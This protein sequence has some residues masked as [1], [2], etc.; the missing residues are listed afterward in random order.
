M[1]K[2]K[3]IMILGAGCYQYPLIKKAKAMELETYVVSCSGA[4]PGIS[5]ADHYLELDT[6]DIEGV[7]RA[8]KDA[9]IDGVVTTGTDVCLPTLGKIVDELQLRGTGFEA[10]CKCADKAA[11]K[12]TFARYDIPNARFTVVQELGQ[13]EKG[14]AGIGYPVMIKATDS[15]GSRGI[16]RVDHP[17]QL[18]A[19][20]ERAA[21][22]SRNGKIIVEEYIS[23]TEFGAQAFVHN[24]KVREVVLHADT[25][26]PPPYCTPVGHSMPI[27]FPA[28]TKRTIHEIVRKVVAGMDIQDTIA[29][30]DFVLADGKP[31]VLEVGARMGATCLPEL[32]STHI[33][34][35]AYEFLIRLALGENPVL[36][37]SREQ[38]CAGVLLQSPVGGILADISIPSEVSCDPAVI[39][40]CLDVKRGDRIN[41]FVTGPDRIGHVVV[42][43]STQA[44]AKAKA[45]ELADRIIFDVEDA[46]E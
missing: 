22:V 33:G 43:G 25:V 16:S 46:T 32:V 34:F 10:A 28:E 13:A 45:R 39:E 11:M 36:P 27:A 26:T 41:A 4:Y 8:A 9:K 12:E 44:E 2:N 3:R 24:N 42:T 23:G 15:S 30:F 1:L 17:D 5:I 31:A 19:G 35:D 37:E 6:T 7:C 38:P 40:I 21:A 14:A 20:W 29:N 18:E